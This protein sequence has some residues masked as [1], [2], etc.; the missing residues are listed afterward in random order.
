ASRLSVPVV[1]VRL[2]GVDQVLHPSW[3]MARPGRVT[4][5]FGAPLSLKGQDYTALAKQVEE[6]VKAL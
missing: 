4:V 6:A 2:K 5:T 3:R 1:P